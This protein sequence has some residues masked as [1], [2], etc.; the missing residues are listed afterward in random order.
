MI[1]KKSFFVIRRRITKKWNNKKD[2][3]YNFIIFLVTDNIYCVYLCIVLLQYLQKFSSSRLSHYYKNHD[4]FIS[5]LILSTIFQR[6]HG[7][8]HIYRIKKQFVKIFKL[9]TS[10]LILPHNQIIKI[11]LSLL[12]FQIF[13][14]NYT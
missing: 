4:N 9:I 8:E 14:I 12:A 7:Q 2:K 3:I 5:P 11:S 10:Y 6:K 13:W 1:L